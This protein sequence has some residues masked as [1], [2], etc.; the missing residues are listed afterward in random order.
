MTTA[1]TPRPPVL[2]PNQAERM[3]SVRGFEEVIKS[4]ADSIPELQARPEI[5]EA[6]AELVDEFEIKPSLFEDEGRTIVFAAIAAHYAEMKSLG[7]DAHEQEKTFVYNTVALLAAAHSDRLEDVKIQLEQEN[8]LF[9]SEA[10]IRAY[11]R[12]T[13]KRLT[14]E[15]KD[16]I[17]TAGLLDDVKKRLGI[18]EDN[19]DEYDLRVLTIGSDQQTHG[20]DAKRVDYE[21]ID[22]KNPDDRA[23]LASAE[24]ERQDIAAWK[25]E[26][27]KR[28]QDFAR[29]IGRNSEFADAWVNTT[30]G[31][32]TLCISMPLA[33][34]ILDPTVT[35]NTGYWNDDARMRDFAILEHEYTHTQGGANID[36]DVVFGINIEEFRAEH[37]SGNKHGYQDIKGFFRDLNIVTGLN[38]AEVLERAPKGGTQTEVY[39]TIAN[40][41]GLKN[42]LGVLLAMPKNYVEGQSNSLIKESVA[43]LEGLDGVLATVLASELE[44]GRGQEVEQR[45]NVAAERI[46]D[47]AN[48]PEAVISVEGYAAYRKR[49]GSI[50]VTDLILERIDALQKE[51]VA[52]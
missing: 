11:D 1:S 27:A 44:K 38:I 48:K 4:M 10:Q 36:K 19:E 16:R 49:H 7:D 21:G 46:L 14:A 51:K 17:A 42:L 6:G 23:A 45:V 50:T 24:V 25:K 22:F 41:V 5:V 40:T 39:S 18:T 15:V 9:D 37:F 28:G 20:L 33:E 35:A 30:E 43:Y 47:V 52:L 31:K 34:K 26:L 8:G 12:Y 3:S 32:Q 29:E 13:D 2:E